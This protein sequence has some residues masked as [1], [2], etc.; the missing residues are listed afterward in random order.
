MLVTKSLLILIAITGA[1]AATDDQFATEQDLCTK[2]AKYVC[3]TRINP[4]A[5]ANIESVLLTKMRHPEIQKYVRTHIKIPKASY[6]HL[7]IQCDKLSKKE[8]ADNCIELQQK[9]KRTKDY[10]QCQDLNSSWAL[11]KNAQT[12]SSNEQHCWDMV[13]KAIET[14]YTPARRKKAEAIF[15]S[16]KEKI[17]GFLK[18]RRTLLET[19]EFNANKTEAMSELDHMIKRLHSAKVD[20]SAP[21]INIPKVIK[22]QSDIGEIPADL[23]IR[24]GALTDVTTKTTRLNFYVSLVEEFPDVVTAVLLHELAHVMIYKKVQA[25]ADDESAEQ[26]YDI[27]S[28][29]KSGFPF[30]EERRCFKR[31]DSISPATADVACL[32]SK[33]GALK[34]VEIPDAIKEYM[35]ALESDSDRLPIA[36]SQGVFDE[37]RASQVFEAF[38]DWIATEVFWENHPLAL[39]ELPKSGGLLNVSRIFRDNPEAF[40]TVVSM[41]ADLKLI[42][43][44]LLPYD[45]ASTSDELDDHPKSEDRISKIFFAHPKAKSA[46][47]CRRKFTNRIK[48]LS[49]P[50]KEDVPAYCSSALYPPKKP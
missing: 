21:E 1:Q 33:L 36:W 27:E 16:A 24:D 29:N 5:K 50:V 12:R 31:R 3:D 7:S 18:K 47:G 14:E 34:S 19:I 11:A 48:T 43:Q 15:E 49:D 44:G 4:A 42:R 30:R 37:C 35:K 32:K 10:L 45:S 28:I 25:I 39:V 23:L 13:V 9:L 6:A 17:I 2:P 22:L 8:A 46:L 20:T 26:K 41:C 38:A 40:A